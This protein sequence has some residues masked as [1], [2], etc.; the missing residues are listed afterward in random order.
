M[1]SIL[2][3]I[4]IYQLVQTLIRGADTKIHRDRMMILLAYYFSF[5][6]ENRLK[7]TKCI[8]WAE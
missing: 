8:T 4:K 2:N 6:K 7:I 3:F 1:T 5:G